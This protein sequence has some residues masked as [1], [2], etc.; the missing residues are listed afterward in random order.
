LFLSLW[1]DCQHANPVCGLA[2]C[3]TTAP[4]GRECHAQREKFVKFAQFVAK[5]CFSVD[6]EKGWRISTRALKMAAFAV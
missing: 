3:F 1:A 4:F 5:M 6:F 2:C